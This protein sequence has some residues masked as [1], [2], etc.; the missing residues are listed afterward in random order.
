MDKQLFCTWHFKEL[1]IA[2]CSLCYGDNQ[3]QALARFCFFS[4]FFPINQFRAVFSLLPHVAMTSVS[5]VL[6][7][8]LGEFVVFYFQFPSV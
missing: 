2:N 6:G 5:L 4:F 3:N 7:Y 1:P 8:F